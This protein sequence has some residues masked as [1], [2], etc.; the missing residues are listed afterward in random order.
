V[1]NG[2]EEMCDTERATG[3]ACAKVDEIKQFHHF[4]IIALMRHLGQTDVHLDMA[5]LNELMGQRPLYFQATIP[6]EG[7]LRIQVSEVAL[8]LLAPAANEIPL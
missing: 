2:L 8:E 7:G 1:T 6:A 3:V 4:M 5:R